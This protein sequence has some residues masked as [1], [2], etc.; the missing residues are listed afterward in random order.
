MPKKFKEGK[1][2]KGEKIKVDEIIKLDK[3]SNSDNDA[4]T[5]DPSPPKKKFYKRVWFWL[6]IVTALALV[7]GGVFLGIYFNNQNK[8]RQIISQG[9]HDITLQST[10]VINL[11]NKIQTKESFDAYSLELQKLHAMVR[12]NKFNAQKMKY[13]AVDGQ[14]YNIFLDDFDRYINNSV[15]HA[16]KISEFSQD[17]SDSL[18]DLSRIAKES[19]DDLRA[20]AS[21]LSEPMPSGIFNIA[22][23]LSSANQLLLTKELSIKAKQQ[24]DEVATAKD[25]ADKK[26][27]EAVVDNYLN[28]YIVGSA[29]TMRRYMTEAF[30]KEYDFNQLTAEARQY[31]YPASFRRISGQKDS[32]GKYKVQANLVYKLRNGSGQYTVGSELSVVYVESSATWMIDSVKEGSSF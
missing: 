11:E 31:S 29:T 21:Y 24:A 14:Y 30:Q 26:L 27:A 1:E 7:A 8:N 22:Q 13:V 3:T 20:N 10:S 18:K 25:V 6:V 17:N 19:S 4:P 32:T 15:E 23:V 16:N 2:N 12:N 28:A 5:P 9:W